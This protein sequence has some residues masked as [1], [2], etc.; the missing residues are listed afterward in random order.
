MKTV[1][2][3][4]TAATPS[5]LNNVSIDPGVAGR[6]Y[7]LHFDRLAGFRLGDGAALLLATASRFARKRFGHFRTEFTDVLRSSHQTKT[8]AVMQRGDFG[9]NVCPV[10]RKLDADIYQLAGDSYRY[11][12]CDCHGENDYQKYSRNSPQAKRFQQSHEW[13]EQ[14]AEEH[15]QGKGNQDSSG[16]VLGPQLRPLRLQ[17]RTASKCLNWSDVESMHNRSTARN[18]KSNGLT[19]RGA[20]NAGHPVLVAVESTAASS[21]EQRRDELMAG[22]GALTCLRLGQRAAT[23]ASWLSSSELWR[24]FYGPLRGQWQSPVSCWLP[25]RLCRPFR[26]EGFPSVHGVLHSPH[27]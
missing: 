2:T 27:F 26:N 11:E 23:P 18:N 15:R 8:P 22:G 6:C 5:G 1:K 19:N 4:T 9:F 13:G 3:S 7:H 10:S 17:A 16:E 14:K 21:A 12:D 20:N 24:L 25:L